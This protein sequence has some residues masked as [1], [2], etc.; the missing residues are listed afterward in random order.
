MFSSNFVENFLT[1]YHTPFSLHAQC[2][3]LVNNE[4]LPQH[5]WSWKDGVSKVVFFTKAQVPIVLS[6]IE[7]RTQ[8]LFQHGIYAA[9]GVNSTI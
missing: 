1:A 5:H 6:D 3:L 8:V 4:N 9:T 2:D 7:T